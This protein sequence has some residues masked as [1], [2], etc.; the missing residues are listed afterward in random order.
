MSQTVP[1]DFDEDGYLA[2]NPDVAEAV[3]RGG[4]TSGLQHYL[5]YGA[6]ENRDMRPGVRA[7]PFKYPFRQGLLPQRRD[8]ILAGLD[9]PSLAGVEIGALTRP[10]VAKSE[11][12]IFYVDH[13][14]T[15]TLKDQY[16]LHHWVDTTQIVDV[17]GI[18]GNN[19]L[20]DCIG[21][22]RKVDYVVAS[23]VIEHTPDMITWLGEIRA[24]LV[25]NGTLRLAIPDRRYTFD[26]LRFETR[27][28]DVLD[29][30]LQRT[31]TPLPRLVIEHHSLLRQVDAKAAW[32]GTLNRS[33]LE[34]YS[35][36]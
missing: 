29:A 14:G 8:K 11:G 32:D 12:N 31:R 5:L 18:W 19:S 6:A 7:V 33:D 1:P 36:V 13:A 16:R 20:Q 2:A 17:E 30:Y 28:H 34:R 21:P 15:N 23:H 25:P 22:G 24:I 9:L 4:L 10:L 35:T 26:Y 3:A 27:V